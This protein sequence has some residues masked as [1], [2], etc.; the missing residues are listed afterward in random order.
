MSLTRR[1]LTALLLA[2]TLSGCRFLGLSGPTTVG[3]G[4]HYAT[5]NKVFDEYFVELYQ[6]QVK[7]A[8]APTQLQ[9]ARQTLAK[10]AE[11]EAS[12]PNAELVDK[13]HARLEKLVA[14]GVRV[15]LEVT[16]PDPPD[17]AQTS[18]SV[19]H[20]GTPSST[21]GDLL[22]SIET[23]LTTLAKLRASMTLAPPRLT[24]LRL[25]AGQLDA[26]I[27]EAFDLGSPTK[28]AEVRANLDDAVKVIALMLDR[29]KVVETESTELV[30]LVVDKAGTDDGS[31]GSAPSTPPAPPAAKPE[32]RPP[33]PRPAPR[34]SPPPAATPAP[35]PP[36][37]APPPPAPPPPKPAPKSADFEP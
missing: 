23:A 21:D 37:P 3:Q 32:P 35:A 16:A 6:F 22:T 4:K 8:D 2:T 17:P 5:G 31:V 9:T 28:R 27:D 24:E 14:K 29:A 30:T 11:I 10:A 1:T 7:L 12:K 18:A 20:S 19:K 36:P 26:Q 13:L 15:K 33:A 34:P 25:L